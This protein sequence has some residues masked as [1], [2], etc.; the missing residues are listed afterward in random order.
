MLIDEPRWR[1]H[2]TR[3][4]HLVSDTSFEELH[5]FASSLT[6][7][8]PLRFHRDHYDVPAAYWQQVVDAGARVTSTREI[9]R[10]LRAAGLRATS[11]LT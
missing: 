4:A 3:F 9:V 2:D 11:R 8:R 10:T 1:A 6:V 5:V 7:G